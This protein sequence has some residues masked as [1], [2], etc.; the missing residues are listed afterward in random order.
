LLAGF[1]VRPPA[2][3][4]A[5]VFFFAFLAAPRLPAA[6]RFRAAAAVFLLVVFFF[7]VD[8]AMAQQCSAALI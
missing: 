3:L 2:R 1:V 4:R 7:V 8:F 5:A 6:L